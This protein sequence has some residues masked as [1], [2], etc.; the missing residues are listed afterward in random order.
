MRDANW[1][2]PFFFLPLSSSHFKD[3]SVGKREYI[4]YITDKQGKKKT[5]KKNK[6]I[7]IINKLQ[8]ICIN[9]SI[10]NKN[11][12]WFYDSV[13]LNALNTQLLVSLSD[14]LRRDCLLCMLWSNDSGFKAWGGV[15]GVGKR[16]GA[17][18]KKVICGQSREKFTADLMFPGSRWGEVQ[19]SQL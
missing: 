4:M 13:F 18:N 16:C 14:H 17:R 2:F 11:H 10:S 3:V 1:S 6:T 5:K 8:C 9:I 12:I 15:T 7:W 19:N